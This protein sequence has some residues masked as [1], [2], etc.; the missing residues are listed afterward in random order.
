MAAGLYAAIRMFYTIFINPRKAWVLA[1]SFDQLANTAANGNPD[2]T[3]SSRAFRAQTEGKAWGC[4]LCK[5]L[6]YVDKNH[7]KESEGV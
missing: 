5:L 6:N 3:I 1:V 4:V 7:C 2:E